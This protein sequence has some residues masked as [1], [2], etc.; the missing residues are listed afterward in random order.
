MVIQAICRDSS[1][2]TAADRKITDQSYLIEINKVNENIADE[3]RL[4]LTHYAEITSFINEKIRK[5]MLP[6]GKSEC[7]IYKARNS[8][9]SGSE[10]N[11]RQS[12]HDNKR[13]CRAFGNSKNRGHIGR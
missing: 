13:H 1:L 11:K 2:K 9:D 3:L 12:R 8:N 6:I 10:D 5:A 4:L 7:G